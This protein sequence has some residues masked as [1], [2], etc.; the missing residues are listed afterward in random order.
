MTRA[1]WM[2]VLLA[3][4]AACSKDKAIDLPAKLTPYTSTLH[5]KHVWSA[6]VDDEHAAPLRL[7]LGLSAA[8]DRVY[9]AGHKGNVTAFDVA[10]GHKLWKAHLKAPLSGGTAVGDGMVLIGSSDGRL[11][12]L[13]A[14]SGQ[15]RWSVRVNGEVLAPAGV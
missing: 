6:R 7:A 9:A 4:I 13:D 1:L 11:F 5:V 14:A 8:D 10:T 15:N 2:M 3:A 12:A